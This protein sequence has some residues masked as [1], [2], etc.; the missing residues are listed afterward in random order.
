MEW[1]DRMN[2]AIDYLEAHLCDDINP[3]EISRI[4]ACPYSVFQRSFAPITG[5]QLSEY[6][7]RRRLSCAAYDLQ[8]THQRILDIA[9]KYGYDSADAFAAAFK[10]MHGITPQEARRPEANLK[11]YARL[12]FTLM[13]TGVQEMD[14]RVVDRNV[15][16][17]LGIRR[18]TPSGGGTWGTVKSDGTR[19]KMEE[20]AEHK[21]DLGLCF[22]FD[23]EGNNDY[24]CGVEYD[25][26]DILGFD[27]YQYPEAVWLVFAAKGTISS[28][29]FG[30]TWK[31][32]YGEFMPHSEY[33][34]L[35]LPTIE[36]YIEW[37]EASDVCNVEIMI[38]VQ[39]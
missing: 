21:C 9:V 7:R 29:V 39:K 1:V 32:I 33:R 36:K 20:I 23:S 35:D 22:G 16:R 13:I 14:Y 6:L 31:R 28:G 12:T 10:R 15:F 11:F 18:T 8:H 4:M 2:H 27:Y 17:V 3:D 34:Q 25:G 24:M 19:E 37:N 38:P 5:I 26:E 30:Q